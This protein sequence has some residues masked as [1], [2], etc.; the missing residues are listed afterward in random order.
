MSKNKLSVDY[1]FNFTLIALTASCKEYK[2]A[3]ILNRDFDLSLSKEPNIDIEFVAGKTMSISNYLTTTEHQSIRLLG[4]K[5]LNVEEKFNAYLIPEL[6]NFDYFVIVNDESQTFN[7]E[8][9][10][11]KIKSIPIVQFAVLVDPLSIKSKDNL[12]F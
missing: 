2:L 5:A 12:I 11:E 3:W 9:F 10:I 1:D 6:K 8:T 4:N 7:P